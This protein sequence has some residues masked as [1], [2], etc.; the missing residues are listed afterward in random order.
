MMST[1]HITAATLTHCI[2]TY[3]NGMCRYHAQLT[4]EWLGLDST[5]R[6][7]ILT[8][9]LS[10]INGALSVNDIQAIADHCC[11]QLCGD[12]SAPKSAQIDILGFRWADQ[13]SLVPGDGIAVLAEYEI[14]QLLQNGYS[15]LRLQAKVTKDGIVRVIRA[16]KHGTLMQAAIMPGQPVVARNWQAA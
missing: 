6:E 2:G 5:S 13:L 1:F 11:Q 14:K 4:Q 12:G 8:V 15:D 10:S 16:K 3:K 7:A 9:S